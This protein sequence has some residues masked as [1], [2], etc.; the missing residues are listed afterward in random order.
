M[1]VVHGMPPYAAEVAVAASANCGIA[2]RE[3]P[4]GAEAAA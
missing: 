1:G 3:S 2:G 4:T